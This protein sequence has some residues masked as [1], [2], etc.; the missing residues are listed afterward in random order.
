V[1]QGASAGVQAVAGAGNGASIKDQMDAI[2]LNAAEQLAAF[3]VKTAEANFQ[4]DTR[5]A[6]LEVKH[7]ENTVETHEMI[8]KNNVAISQSNVEI[9]E[10]KVGHE[11]FKLDLAKTDATASRAERKADK[12]SERVV[13]EVAE[14]KMTKSTAKRF[15]P[16]PVDSDEDVDSDPFAHLTGN[17]SL[18]PTHYGQAAAAAG[19]TNISFLI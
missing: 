2:N 11:R 7:H 6:A 5:I 18:A 3:E 1:S 12:V 14:K 13:L 17:A 16:K 15:P 8:N 9:S 4:K 10:L 19:K